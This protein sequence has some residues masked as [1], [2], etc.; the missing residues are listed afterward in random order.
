MGD[1]PAPSIRDVIDRSPVSRFQR[2]TVLLCFLLGIADG[3]DA[4]AIGYLLPAMAAEWEVPAG[5]FGPA[6]TVGLIGMIVGTTLVAPLADRVGRR[7]VLLGATLLYGAVTATIPLVS[8]VGELAGVRFVAGIGLGAVVPNLVALSS[9]YMPARARGRAVLIVLCGI[10][11]GGFLCGIVAGRLVPT[12]GWRSVFLVGAILPIVLVVVCWRL[13]PDS[14]GML[15]RRGRPDAAR[16]LL[17]RISPE[18][19][20]T[21]LDDSLSGSAPRTARIPVGSLF[22]SRSRATTLLWITWFA[23]YVIVYFLYSWLPTLLVDVGVDQGVAI[24]AMSL[25]L[26][27][28]TVGGLSQGALIDRRGDYFSLTV[29]LPVAVLVI[30][31]VPSTFGQPVLLTFLICL[32]GFFAVGV[33][34]AL[35]TITAEIYPIDVRATGIGWAFGAGRVG[36]LVAPLAGGLLMTTGVPGAVIFQLIAVPAAVGAISLVLLVLLVHRT[37]RRATAMAP[38]GTHPTAADAG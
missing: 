21:P 15:V 5:S 11:I 19:A 1:S 3:F 29:G 22:G 17:A 34:Q 7:A 2:R 36:S 26:L 25:C 27:A 32:I 28:N 30:L 10:T 16:A 33:N 31:A 18:L 24:L 4:L 8:T 9:E 23:T 37:R 20:T 6:I 13:L 38:S 12:L 35:S 14:I